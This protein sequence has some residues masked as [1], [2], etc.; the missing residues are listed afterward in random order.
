LRRRARGA[1]RAVQAAALHIVAAAALAGCGAAA[2]PVGTPDSLET[3]NARPLPPDPAMAAVAIGENGPCLMGD[4]GAVDPPLVPQILVQDRRTPNIAGFLVQSAT[5]F[6]SCIV[7]RSSGMAGGGYGDPLGPMT[8]NLTIDSQGRG[9]VGDG[10]A[11]ELGGRVA[12]PGAQVVVRLENGQN[13]MA[14]VANGFWLAWW[15]ASNRA[16][17][18]VAVDGSGGQLARVEVVEP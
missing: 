16:T 10:E 11:E 1:R 4:A 3:W 8:S 17:S 18:V 12:L 5:H 13:V 9:T 7:S 14:S 15:P 6:G 2:F